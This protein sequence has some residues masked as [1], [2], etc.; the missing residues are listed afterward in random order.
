MSVGYSTYCSLLKVHTIEQSLN[1]DF[2]CIEQVKNSQYLELSHDLEIDKAIMFL[3][4]KDFQ[5]VC[6]TNLG[7]EFVLRTWMGC[8]L[9]CKAFYHHSDLH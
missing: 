5:Q 7:S 8:Q 1:F 4:L 3:K 2:R 9:V 6:V